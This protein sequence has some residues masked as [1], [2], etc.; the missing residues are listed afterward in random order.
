MGDMPDK[1]QTPLQR[2]TNDLAFAAY[3]VI[4]G[5]KVLQAKDLS[6]GGGVYGYS[7]IFETTDKQWE[8][9]H[10]DFVNSEAAVFD[11]AVRTLKK[12]CKRNADS[13]VT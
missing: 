9:V 7:F 2:V 8:R 10:V 1:A 13:G 6:R 5:I 11:S 3:A 12:L 4:K